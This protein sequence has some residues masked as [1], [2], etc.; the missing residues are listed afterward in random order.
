MADDLQKKCDS[1]FA[2]L[3]RNPGKKDI[4]ASAYIREFF[5]TCRCDGV[6]DLSAQR[7][8]YRSKVDADEKGRLARI[9]LFKETDMD[10]K[11]AAQAALHYDEWHETALVKALTWPS[12]IK[13]HTIVRAE[14]TAAIVGIAGATYAGARVA[15]SSFRYLKGVSVAKDAARAVAAARGANTPPDTTGGTK[16]T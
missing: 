15:E 14:R 16:P 4:L 5:E 13:Y 2:N 3:L 10:E 12:W 7:E 11:V 9:L 8:E 1:I 6:H